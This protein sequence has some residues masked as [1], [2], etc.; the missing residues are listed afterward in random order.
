MGSSLGSGRLTNQNLNMYA[1][2]YTQRSVLVGILLS[3]A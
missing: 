3:D 1:F 2:T